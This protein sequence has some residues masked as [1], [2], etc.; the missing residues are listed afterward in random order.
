MLPLIL[1]TV[2]LWVCHLHTTVDVVL[3]ELSSFQYSFRANQNTG[4][5]G[6]KSKKNKKKKGDKSKLNRDPGKNIDVKIR[7]ENG[8]DEIEAEVTD[9][10]TLTEIELSS[11]EVEGSKKNSKANNAI[12][13]ANGTSLV[14]R[15]AIS[16]EADAEIS[17]EMR[18]VEDDEVQSS[19]EVEAATLLQLS[20][21]SISK[22]SDKNTEARLDAL[23]RERS[24]LREEVAQLR[25]SLEEI[26]EKHEEDLLSIREQLEEAHGDKEHAETQYRNLLGKVNTIKSQLGD[27]LKADAVCLCLHS[28]NRQA[29]FETGRSVASEDSNR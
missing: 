27:R 11:N 28:A 9:S 16:P 14:S 17:G 13:I 24:A 20:R 3:L 23:A 26:Q 21:D 25:R 18:D 8:N 4:I 29:Y 19:H 6:S 1:Y 22:S 5:S 15:N 7:Q 2:I 10:K 12:S